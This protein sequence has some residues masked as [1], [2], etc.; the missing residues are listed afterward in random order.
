MD[1]QRLT[2]VL[3]EGGHEARVSICD[4]FSGDAIVWID[5]VKVESCHPFHGNRLVTQDEDGR[6]RTIVVSDELQRVIAIIIA[7]VITAAVVAAFIIT[8]IIIII[9][10]VVVI[11]VVTRVV[12]V[13]IV[14]CVV[15]IAI[16][17]VVIVLIIIVATELSSES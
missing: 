5:M 8:A 6:F 1:S 15:V 2:Q 10:A 12:I 3:H 14:A 11:N 7:A 17:V 4:H 13:T 9:A 16:I